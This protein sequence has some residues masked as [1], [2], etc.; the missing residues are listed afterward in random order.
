LDPVL[1]AEDTSAKQVNDGTWALERSIFRGRIRENDSRSFIDEPSLL[2]DAFESDW[3]LTKVHRVIRTES[4]VARLKQIMR[5]AYPVLREA[6]RAYA[7]SNPQGEPFDISFTEYSLMFR[8]IGLE[9]LADTRHAETNVKGV[10][11][12]QRVL[13]GGRLL[14]L[15]WVATNYDAEP[16]EFNPSDSCVR[17][18]FLE[19]IFRIGVALYPPESPKDDA[20]KVAA[21]E[22]ML[23]HDVLPQFRRRLGVHHSMRAIKAARDEL[24]A[25]VGLP[26]GRA[27]E[28]EAA[29]LM[30]I[31][32]NPEQQCTT[33]G[34]SARKQCRLMARDGGPLLRPEQTAAPGS[35]SVGG[36]WAEQS[37]LRWQ[38][39]MQ[40]ASRR[41]LLQGVH[42]ALDSQQGM[43]GPVIGE[44]TAPS[45]QGTSQS[46][47]ATGSGTGGGVHSPRRPAPAPPRRDSPLKP[48][49]RK[50]PA[51]GSAVAPPDDSDAASQ[52]SDRKRRGSR[53]RRPSVGGI[54]WDVSVDIPEELAP[55]ADGGEPLARGDADILSNAFRA[56]WLYREDVDRVMRKHASGLR[57]CY[58]KYSGREAKPG[59]KKLFMSLPEWVDLCR[60]AGIVPDLAGDREIRSAFV[61]SAM[62]TVDEI[63]RD[64][65]MMAVDA[66]DAHTESE[67]L[68]TVARLAAICEGL[69]SYGLD[70]E[71]AIAD[72]RRAMRKARSKAAHR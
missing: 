19:A 70:S 58:E 32:L 43:A 60:D 66:V 31:A 27:R 42:L 9:E 50:R 71:Q 6:F 40:A 7:L 36:L 23:R 49:P 46:D 5:Q 21:V 67:F 35:H 69:A 30:A 33:E 10:A 41:N 39:G 64:E 26:G 55:M 72:V 44:A 38:E 34:Q 3:T 45:S 37:K 8:E 12:S 11:A 22:R 2:H 68:E 28:A 63:N 18:E 13:P 65:K 51:S 29:P 62:T 57:Q 56:L 16:S 24:V 25:C 53:K 17:F 54:R 20:G 14:Q 15:A 4:Q 48:P 59:M 1:D 61:W 47:E 52:G